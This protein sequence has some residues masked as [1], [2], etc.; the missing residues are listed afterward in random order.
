M[1]EVVTGDLLAC[2]EKYL[3]HQTNCVTTRSKHLA[4]SVFT[5]FPYA[6][7]YRTRTKHSFPGSIIVKGDGQD[8]RFV[9]NMLGQYYPGY[10]RPKKDS[11]QTRLSHF[12]SCLEKMKSLEGDFAFPWRIGCGAAGGDW[13]LYLKLIEKFENDIA[14]DVSIY[15]LPGVSILLP[16]FKTLF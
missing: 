8:Q 7:I 10:A 4:K 13:D 9:V 1:L 16:E 5:R 3:C 14:G 6:D 2:A 11:K 15:K 12:S